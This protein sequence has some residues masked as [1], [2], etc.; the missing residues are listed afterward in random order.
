MQRELRS[1]AGKNCYIS[2]FCSEAIAGSRAF[3]GLGGSDAAFFFVS[4]WYFS[5]F[6]EAYV[7]P[8]TRVP[9]VLPGTPMIVEIAVGIGVGGVVIRGIG[10]TKETN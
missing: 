3:L 4:P 10:S 8:D 1:A 7:P 9:A 5:V 6:V 2:G